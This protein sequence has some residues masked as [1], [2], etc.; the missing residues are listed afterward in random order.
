ML[1]GIHASVNG[2]LVNAL[3][4]LH[5]LNLG[6]GQIFTS[7]QKQW[8][9]RPVTQEEEKEFREDETLTI[10]SHASYLINLSSTKS[11]VPWLSARALGEELIRMQK[12]S[13]RWLVMHPGAHLNAGEDQ[14]IEMIAAGV[15][16]ILNDG[17]EKT[18]ILF[19]NTAGQGTTL[20]YSFEQLAKLLKLTDMPCRTGICFDTC[21]AFAAG[22][23]LSSNDAVSRTMQEFDEVVGLEKIKVF[24]INDSK[25]EL[26]SRLDRHARIGEGFIGMEPLQ[27]L[28][29]M[30]VFKK[31]PGIT[32]TPGSD[33]DRAED[34]FSVMKK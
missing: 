2:G 9:G 17:P 28:A 29:S 4:T 21:H 11:R 18:A 23:D 12:L 16:K 24:H 15:R 27:F 33:S 3:S 1:P 7:N 26:G 25:K 8:K 5:E 32:E 13:I 19:E 30:E 6:S 34:A 20:G 14:A 22:Y 10:I 31:I